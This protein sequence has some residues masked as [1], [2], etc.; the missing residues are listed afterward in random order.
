M[1]F[2]RTN[3]VHSVMCNQVL[4]CFR[5]YFRA[6]CSA[7]VAFF[8]ITTV[9]SYKLDVVTITSV[10]NSIRNIIFFEW[11]YSSHWPICESGTSCSLILV[12]GLSSRAALIGIRRRRSAS[13]PLHLL[14]RGNPEWQTL[15]IFSN[16]SELNYFGWTVLFD[17]KNCF[18]HCR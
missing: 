15:A 11:Y 9:C 12:V 16:I 13:A 6:T 18:L 14:Q 4:F 2:H 3:H 5:K 1:S 10:S 8:C 17:Y 7:P